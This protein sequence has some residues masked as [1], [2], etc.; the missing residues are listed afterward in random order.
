MKSI[1]RPF[2]RLG[3]A[4]SGALLL[5]DLFGSGVQAQSPT[6]A[7]LEIAQLPLLTERQPVESTVDS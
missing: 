3:S 7:E 2:I 1:I 4:A 5:A 6:L